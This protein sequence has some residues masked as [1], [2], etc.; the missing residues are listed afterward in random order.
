MGGPLLQAWGDQVNLQMELARSLSNPGETADQAADW[1]MQCLRR[2]K[3]NP[4]MLE[5]Q[6][7]GAGDLMSQDTVENSHLNQ[8]QLLTPDIQ[9]DVG[10][11]G[12]EA[13]VQKANA[14][15]DRRLDRYYSKHT[16]KH[17]STNVSPLPCLWRIQP[18]F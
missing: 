12:N 17:S 13:P 3:M 2:Q 7:H 11:R 4:L 14:K 16:A 18:Y 6:E 1:K 10:D 8:M 9:E 15:S 5:S